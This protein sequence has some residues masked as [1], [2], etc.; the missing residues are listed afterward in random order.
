MAPEPSQ[1][2]P[3]A[4][5]GRGFYNR[6]SALQASGISLLLPIWASVCQ[7]V[8]CAGEPLV[9]VDYAS[10][11]GRNSMAPMRMAIEELRRRTGHEAPIEVIH[12]DLPS[13]DFPSLFNAL[14]DDESSYMAGLA[15]VFPAAIGRS[16]FQ[17][18]LPSGRV[19]LGW[20]TF[21]VQ[22][23][24]R[25]TGDVPD[26]IMAGLSRIASVA[27]AVKSQLALD[28]DRFLEARS[29]EMRIG[30][31]LLTAFTARLDD[32]SGWE[33]LTGELWAAV[34]D[35]VRAGLLSPQEQRHLTIPIGFRSLDEVKAPFSARGQF[36]GLELERTELLKIPDPFWPDYEN[37]KDRTLLGQRHADLTRAWAAPTLSGLMDPGRNRSALM[38]DLFARFAVRVAANPCQH[39]PYMVVA[40]LTKRR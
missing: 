2:G 15:N 34:E 25:N 24:S 36:A 18:L 39:E 29:S 8:A 38:D 31:K 27:N 4:M 19:H 22:W 32:V 9:I 16:Y 26:Q 12:T 21:S 3:S 14:Q 5:E 6:N 37:S 10:S 33:W 30:A 7:T 35:Q 23:M 20:N 17:P 28:W 40:V 1:L 11:Q 13:N